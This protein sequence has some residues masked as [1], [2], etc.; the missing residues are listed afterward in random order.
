MA[1]YDTLQLKEKLPRDD[2]TGKYQYPG[3]NTEGLANKEEDSLLSHWLPRGQN[4]FE[5]N[6]RKGLL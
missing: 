2:E 1:K 4:S 5:L 3:R 6:S